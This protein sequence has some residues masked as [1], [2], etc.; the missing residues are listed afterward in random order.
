MFLGEFAQQ[1]EIS[2]TR[3]NKPHIARDRLD[4]H[5]RNSIALTFHD[6]VDRVLIV[7]RHGNRIRCR[8]LRHAGRTRHTERRHAGTCTDEQTVAMSVVAANELHNLIAPRIA[9]SQTE[10][11]HRRLCP[12]VYHA[13]DLDRRVDRLHK[14]CKLSLKECRCT[15]ACSVRHSLLQSLDHLRVR[16]PN[17]HR[18]P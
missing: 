8:P 18:S 4:D 2:L 1:G 11:T 9:A 13:D 3:Q 14:F 6:G 17:N 15:V 12:R 16:M 7:V 5:R 10:S